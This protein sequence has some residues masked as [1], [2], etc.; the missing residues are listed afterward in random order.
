MRLRPVARVAA[1]AIAAFLG[2]AAAAGGLTAHYAGFITPGQGS[3]LAS[4]E[5]VTMV[6]FGGMAAGLA[7]GT[8]AGLA[9]LRPGLY[10]PHLLPF[11]MPSATDFSLALLILVLL[12]R[13]QGLFGERI[14]ERL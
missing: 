11:G 13:P 14:I 12:F 9:Q 5:L 8:R 2:L 3:F 6:V 7:L 4:I 10:F 1:L